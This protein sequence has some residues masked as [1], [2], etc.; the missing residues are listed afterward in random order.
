M[1]ELQKE[2]LKNKEIAEKLSS[3]YVVSGS[4][5]KI[6][7][8]FQ[9]SMELF[10]TDEEKLLASQRWEKNW[11]D[12]SGIKKDLSGKIIDGLN[13]K[14]INELDH[15]DSINPKAYELY[16]KAKHTFRNRKTTQ[17]KEVAMGLIEKALSLDPDFLIAKIYQ[18]L[19]YMGNEPDKALV[20]LEEANEL[21]LKTNQI[22][23]L[24]NIK[25][26]MGGI[27]GERL[28]LEKS[29]KYV[30]ENHRL[31]K[32]LGN[33]SLIAFSKLRIGSH[34]Y[35]A[36]NGDSARFYYND[37]FKLYEELDDERMIHNTMYSLGFIY[38]LWDRELD[39]AL[40]MFEKSYNYDG[41]YWTLSNMGEIYIQKN[42]FDKGL[43]NY[44]KVI[45]HFIS[46]D[47]KSGIAQIN[48][49]YGLYYTKIHDYENE[50][51]PYKISYELYSE[52]KIERWKAH[53]LAG[54]IV[55]YKNIGD[56]ERFQKYY[57]KSSEINTN[58]ASNFYLTL[59][60]KLLISNDINFARDCFFKQLEL[61]KRNNNNDGIINTFT[62]IGLSYF[63]EDDFKNALK[64][65]ES[66]IDHNGLANLYHTTETLTFKHLCEKELGTPVD[67]SFLKQYIDKKMKT[68]KEWF[69]SEP[70]YL[71]W[72]FYKLFGDDKYILEAKKPFDRFSHINVKKVSSYPMYR[73]ILESFKQMQNL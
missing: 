10:D 3:R 43:E 6:D 33:K 59:G 30:R 65:F 73:K 38:W 63:Y 15:D 57:A 21:A 60:F 20:I 47:D 7:S 69:K 70:D 45:K 34:F 36:W 26:M 66:A 67:D 46:V 68:N 11:K 12:L 71:N 28:E 39:K 52:L 2:G 9:L 22:K 61:E 53:S 58:V 27:F 18:G 1:E 35:D 24:M 29:L 50:V 48:R 5:W 25:S 16:L 37:A 44:N 32:K 54:L 31:A 23:G 13:I 42:E 40:T 17:D 64:Y 62:N 55:A 49:L 72:A 41:S 56:R 8:I 51:Q 14:I 4:L 19:M